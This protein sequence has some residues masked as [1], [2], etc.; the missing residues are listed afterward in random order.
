MNRVTPAPTATQPAS[1]R[2][3]N[4]KALSAAHQF[5]AVLLNTLLGSLEHSFSD[6][7]GKKAAVGSDNY[8]YLAMQALASNLSAHGG[9]GIADMI[10]R[11]LQKSGTPATPAANNK[12]AP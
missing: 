6:L 7:P 5:E 10:V 3:T 1:D 11:S 9:I 8:H 4:R 12:K 2:V